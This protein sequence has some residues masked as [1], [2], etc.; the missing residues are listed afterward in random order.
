MP[1]SIVSLIKSLQILEFFRKKSSKTVIIGMSFA[2]KYSIK[3]S[4][5][6]FYVNWDKI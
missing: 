2:S 6:T 5:L 4:D 1:V 3:L